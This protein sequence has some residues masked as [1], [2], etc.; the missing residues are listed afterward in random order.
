MILITGAIG[1]IGRRLVRTLQTRFP[2]SPIRILSRTMP[3]LGLLAAQSQVVVG[4]IA[5][6][7]TAA[8]AV[9]GTLGV[10]HLA[11]K[12]QKNAVTSQEMRRV[13]VYARFKELLQILDICSRGFGGRRFG[14]V[15]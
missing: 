8:E 5:D 7:K 14:R 9:H 4:D 6:S 10:I 12:L 1:F 15:G 13:N 11:A 3:P 2:S